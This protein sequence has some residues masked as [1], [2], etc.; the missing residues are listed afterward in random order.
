MKVPAGTRDKVSSK[1]STM[2]RSTGVAS[3]ASIFSRKRVRRGRAL[4]PAK[5]S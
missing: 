4:G 5:N 2:T 3:S 1:R